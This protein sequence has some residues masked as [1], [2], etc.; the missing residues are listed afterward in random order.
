MQVKTT[1]VRCDDGNARQVLAVRQVVIHERLDHH[2][3]HILVAPAGKQLLLA[4][5]HPKHPGPLDG[6]PHG[7]G[8]HTPLATAQQRVSCRRKR[9]CRSHTQMI[10]PGFAGDRKN[11]WLMSL[12]PKALSPPSNSDGI[13]M[14]GAMIR[15]IKIQSSVN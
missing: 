15:V 4:D 1:L 8:P 11:V 9:E 3:D 6:Q 13:L 12:S 5:E 2:L 14:M 7:C 10:S